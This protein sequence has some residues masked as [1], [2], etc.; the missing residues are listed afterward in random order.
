MKTI[1]IAFTTSRY[2][3]HFKW[4]M[5]SLAKQGGVDKSQRVIVVDL[6]RDK[7][8]FEGE[9]IKHVFPKPTVW[10]GSQR[11]T[12]KDWWAMSN[13]RN[14]AICLCETDYIV[15]LDDRCVLGERWVQGVRDAAENDYAVCGTY[16]KWH[17]MKVVDGRI[18]E[19]GRLDG[20]DS[21]QQTR[22]VENCYHQFW[23]GTMGMPLEWA[24]KVN[25]FEE[26]IDGLGAEDYMMG[27]H[28][29]NAALLTKYDPRIKVIQDR[30]PGECFPV[31]LK[32]SK[33]RFPNDKEDKGHKAIERFGSQTHA[34]HHWNLREIR[35]RVLAGEDFPGTATCPRLDW[36]DGK[37][38]AETVPP[39]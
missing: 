34:S 25:G 22:G 20:K 13:S 36:F 4:F 28:L 17:G 2:E 33:E 39:P 30:T 19:P 6:H 15:F 9:F 32:T 1:T 16:E 23:G 27:M 35:S 5:D 8:N 18:V 31:M 11:L 38:I 37:P 12:D 21:R 29:C 14:T 24:L 10:Q 26:L 3:P 7:R